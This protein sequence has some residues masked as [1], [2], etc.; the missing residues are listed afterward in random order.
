MEAV[1]TF[2]SIRPF[3]QPAYVDQSDLFRSVFADGTELTD[4][5]EVAL[6]EALGMQL[7]DFILNAGWSDLSRQRERLRFLR[8]VMP[9]VKA[10]ADRVERFIDEQEADLADLPILAVELQE[11]EVVVVYV[12]PH[13]IGGLN[14]RTGEA[15]F[16]PLRTWSLSYSPVGFFARTLANL[17]RYAGLAEALRAAAAKQTGSLPFLDRSGGLPPPDGEETTRP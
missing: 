6:W 8:F 16:R 9:Y 14:I 11:N 1:L 2:A 10:W 5:T 15:D 17:P 3:L 4:Q 13:P 12:L 7:D